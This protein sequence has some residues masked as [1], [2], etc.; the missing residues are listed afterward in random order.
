MLWIKPLSL[1]LV[2][3][4]LASVVVTA[5]D[6]AM[7]KQEQC[8]EYGVYQ[9]STENWVDCI[10]Q[11]IAAPSYSE[12]EYVEEVYVED[13]YVEEPYVEDSYIEEPYVEDTYSEEPETD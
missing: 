10:E 2:W 9:D 1:M 12:D 11:E 13:E 8:A 7:S 6:S 3:G 4:C 5:E